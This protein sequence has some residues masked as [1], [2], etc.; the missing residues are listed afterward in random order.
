LNMA[1]NDIIVNSIILEIWYSYQFDVSGS[2]FNHDKCS[3]Q[4]PEKPDKLKMSK[5]FY[6]I[7]L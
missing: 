7:H 1:L 5:L 2:T 3:A 4:P 6:S